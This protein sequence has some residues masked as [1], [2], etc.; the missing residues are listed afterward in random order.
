MLDSAFD[1]LADTQRRQLLVDLLD[2][3]PQSVP[4]LTGVSR[5]LADADGVLLEDRLTST[6][7]I[8][9]VDEYHLRLHCIHV[10]KLV[11]Y[12]F[13]EWDEDG[14]DVT[15]GPRFDEI[16]PLLELLDGRRDELPGEWP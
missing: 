9:D 10:P 7:E 1:A 8:V 3:N 12:G 13:V 5:E 11:E 16:R 2:H 15:K 14:N 4:Q 6:R